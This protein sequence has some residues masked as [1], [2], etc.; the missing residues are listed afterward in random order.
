MTTELKRVLGLK[1][2]V[3]LTIGAV[4]GS[5]IFIVPAVVLRQT[6]GSLTMS[7]L[8]WLVGGILSLLGAL[9]YGELSATNPA[10]GG[11]YIFIRDSFGRLPAF[12]FGWTFFFVITSG[13]VAALAVA[14]TTYLKELVPLTDMMS[15]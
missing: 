6:N 15:N 8:V 13:T 3:L 9:T 5:G 1:D 14:F 2:L 11:L 7:M 4:I 12:L 10:A